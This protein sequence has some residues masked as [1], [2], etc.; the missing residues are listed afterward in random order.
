MTIE[1]DTQLALYRLMLV[2][3]ETDR[4]IGAADGHWHPALGEEAVIA[5]CYHGLRPDDMLMPHY[6]GMIAASY[7]RGADLRKL[8]AGLEG[9]ATSHTRGRY[10]S[11][12]CGPFEH[13][14]VGLYSGAL[15][16]TLEYAAGAALA[17]K[18]DG[19]GAVALAVF[20]DGTASRGNFHEAVNLAA[21][22]KLPVVFVCQNNQLAIS[23][24]PEREHGGRIVDRAAGYGIPGVH[25]DGNDVVTVHEAVQDAI[26]RARRGEGP[27]LIEAFTYR[28]G[29][30]MAADPGT[31]RSQ[32]DVAR[33]AARDPVA[34]QEARLVNENVLDRGALDAMRRE[35]VTEVEAAMEQAKA[36]P[37]PDAAVL[38]LDRVFAGE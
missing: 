9:K 2:T 33:W 12:V 7:A 6:R 37:M 17:A 3:R 32:D 18:L 38:G 19:R 27:T 21:V 10:R 5:G 30:H 14:V 26:E 24:T 28:V 34:M 13:G 25:V 36:D 8:L 31:Y 20:G 23:T 4:V 11:D 35:V 1:H 29:G 16:P 22:L 15:G